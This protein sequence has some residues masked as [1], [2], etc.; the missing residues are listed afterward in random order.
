LIQA[1]SDRM[2]RSARTPG[3]PGTATNLPRLDTRLTP[4]RPEGAVIGNALSGTTSGIVGS[5]G[6]T[7]VGAV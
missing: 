6:A 3:D 7:V 5:V 1:M 4:V 2:R